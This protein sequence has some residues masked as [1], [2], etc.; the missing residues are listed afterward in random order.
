MLLNSLI[1]DSQKGEKN[2]TDCTIFLGGHELSRTTPFGYPPIVFAEI[3]A[4]TQRFMCVKFLLLFS[5]MG[6]VSCNVIQN[7]LDAAAAE[8][9]YADNNLAEM[10]AEDWAKLELSMTE[11]EQDLEMNRN[12]YSAE[13]IKEAGNIQG[14]YAALVIKKGL[15]DLQDA[16]QDFGNQVEGFTEGINSETTKN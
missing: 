12:D 7:K 13:Q 16:V 2:G 4:F 6:L 5:L 1:V 8:I 10:S 9:E 3:S 14:A 11:L 15:N